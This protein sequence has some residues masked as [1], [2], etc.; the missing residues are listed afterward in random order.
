[1]EDKLMKLLSIHLGVDEEKIND[2]ISAETIE[3][4]D[5]LKQMNIIVAVEEEFDIQFDEVESIVSN[6]YQQ[7]LNLI[8]KKTE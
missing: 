7:L 4:W 1:M 3:G 5:S 6:S 8:K 2:D